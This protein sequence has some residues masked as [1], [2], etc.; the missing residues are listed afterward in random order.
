ME[1]IIPHYDEAHDK[2]GKI[3]IFIPQTFAG[4]VGFGWGPET[5]SDF[6]DKLNWAALCSNYMPSEAKDMLTEILMEDFNVEAVHYNFSDDYEDYQDDNDDG[7][8]K[9]YDNL[10]NEEYK[11]KKF[12]GYIDH[13]STPEEKPDNGDI[14]ESKAILRDFLYSKGSYIQ[15]DNDNH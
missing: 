15:L 13:Q 10:N 4:I 6:G 2:Y 3:S 11:V 14:F 5:T 7:Y 9:N 12:Y 8:I 1:H